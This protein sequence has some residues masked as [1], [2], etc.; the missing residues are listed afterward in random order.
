MQAAF[1][2][3]VMSW[4]VFVRWDNWR[5]K[6][7]QT[8]DQ[9]CMEVRGAIFYRRLIVYLGVEHPLIKKAMAAMIHRP[10][11]DEMHI[12]VSLSHVRESSS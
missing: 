8:G 9:L 2:G 1:N 10:S 12:A 7:C 4:R 3:E 5:Y 6:E 11:E